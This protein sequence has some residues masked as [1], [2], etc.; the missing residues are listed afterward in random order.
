MNDKQL[1]QEL[2]KRLE[3]RKEQLEAEPLNLKYKIHNG[4]NL[5]DIITVLKMQSL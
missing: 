5:R 4:H 1:K 2:I 3:I